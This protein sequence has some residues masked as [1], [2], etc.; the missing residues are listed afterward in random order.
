MTVAPSQLLPGERGA[1]RKSPNLVFLEKPQ[2][3]MVAR[4]SLEI[5]GGD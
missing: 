2:A 1:G 4:R 3:V 5:F